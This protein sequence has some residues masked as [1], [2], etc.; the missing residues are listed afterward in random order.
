M[1]RFYGLRAKMQQK[2]KKRVILANITHDLA[3]ID[4]IPV[5]CSIASAGFSTKTEQ[6]NMQSD[7]RF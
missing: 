1:T 5:V 4:T 3:I 6:K 7:L 2:K